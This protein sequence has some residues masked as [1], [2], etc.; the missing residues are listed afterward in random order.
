MPSFRYQPGDKPLDGFTIEQAVGR[1]GFGEVYYAVSDAGRQVALKAVQN[2]EDVELRGIGHVMNLKSPHL[3]SIF[4]IKHNAAND[5]FVVME[6]ISGPSLRD[7]IDD[8]PNGLGE[9]KAAFFLREMAKGISY[10]HDCDVVHRDLKPH[11]VFFEDG[12]VKIGDYSLS[13]LMTMSHRTGHTMTVGSVHYMAPEISLGR[14]DKTV[15]IYALGV[16]LFEMLTGKPPFLGESMGEVLMRHMSG[17]VDTSMLP[18]P[19][20]VV[21]AKALAKDPDE[22]Y[23][24]ADEMAG[25][26]FGHEHI[27]NSVAGFAPTELSIVAR[28][29]AQEVVGSDAQARLQHTPVRDNRTGRDRPRNAGPQR[30]AKAAGQN[31][32]QVPGWLL[33]NVIPGKASVAGRFFGQ[34]LS[35]AAI[36]PVKHHYTSPAEDQL[37]Q[38][39]R[40]ACAAGTI[41]VFSHFA[42]M[43]GAGR[44]SAFI[45][46][47]VMVITLALSHLLRR[48]TPKRSFF[49]TRVST[50]AVVGP[51]TALFCDGPAQISE[52]FGVPILVAILVFDWKQLTDFARPKRIMMLPVVVAA[53]IGFF[54]L[55][56]DFAN[57]NVVLA[58]CSIIIGT[59]IAAQVLFRHDPEQAKRCR[60]EYDWQGTLT[61]LLDGSPL[62]QAE[63]YVPAAA[64]QP[65]FQK[66]VSVHSD[67]DPFAATMLEKENRQKHGLPVGDGFGNI[68]ESP[69]GSPAGSPAVQAVRQDSTPVINTGISDITRLQGMALA[70]LGFI[71]IAGLHRFATG[72]RVSG[73]AWLLTGGLFGIGT[74]VD[75]ILLVTGSFKDAYERPVLSWDWQIPSTQRPVP[76]LNAIT[77]PAKPVN[78]FSSVPKRIPFRSLA[79]SFVGMLTAAFGFFAAVFLSARAVDLAMEWPDVSQSITE[80]FGS[81]RWNSTAEQLLM[82]MAVGGMLLGSALMAVGRARF[83]AGHVLR[84]LFG[85]GALAL[86]CVIG[87]EFFY[88]IDM[89][90]IVES[91][92]RGVIGPFL[93]EIVNNKSIAVLFPT[94]MFFA[95][96]VALV[97]WPPS[98]EKK[99]LS[100]QPE[101]AV[102]DK[103]EQNA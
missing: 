75:L 71:G 62:P 73:I 81:N 42:N 3:V 64:A 21:V 82:M 95:T 78:A 29:V 69:V 59:M 87:H 79:Y 27:Q 37:P 20:D 103:V 53:V 7:I 46:M 4:D 74:I 77:S 31:E 90:A 12:L 100:R 68:P 55:I 34:F 101:N 19:F 41:F 70:M 65:A 30:S 83:G 89:T 23:Q 16:M 24:T 18:K 32:K 99:Q 94:T 98:A 6:Y 25:A 84:L 13:K 43:V 93:E 67:S 36:A 44:G 85:M 35:S 57:E 102:A 56:N 33:T 10:L 47:S 9:A 48:K 26:V 51:L 38:I 60:A 14:Y 80:V 61:S 97:A 66:A 8:S 15:D 58:G 40:I 88:R 11:N 1:G 92:Q 2:F 22:R 17:E 52:N 39:S 49:L 72:R 5:P 91:I 76:A 63:D 50:I 96:G 86:T 45:M 28:K 54:F